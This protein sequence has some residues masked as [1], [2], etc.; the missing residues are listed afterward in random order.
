MRL[1]LMAAI[2]I[3]L[4]NILLQGC[5]WVD[6]TGRQDNLNPILSLKDGDILYQQEEGSFQIDASDGASDP[7]G[8]TLTYRWSELQ[9]QG[10]LQ[11][12]EGTIDLTLAADKLE[13]ICEDKDNCELLFLQ[14]EEHPG[15]YQVMVPKVTAPIGLTHNLHVTDSDGGETVLSTHFCIDSNN[16]AP[17]AIDDN[18]AATEG[19][20]LEVAAP[21]IRDNDTDD[22][23]IRNQELTILGLA[24]GKGPKYAQ[25]GSFVLNSDGSF[26]YG[27]SIFTPLT[28]TQDSFVYEISDGD[29]ISQATVVI[30]LSTQNDPPEVTPISAKIAYIGKLFGPLNVGAHFIDPEGAPM[31]FSISQL[32]TGLRM[33][34]KGIISGSPLIGNQL[35]LH[36]IVISAFDGLHAKSLTLSLTL[37]NNLNKP[38]QLISVIPAINV[39]V[40][41]ALGYNLGQHFKDPENKP[42]KYSAP[43]GLP[44]SFIIQPNGI[45]NGQAVLADIGSH[46]VTLVVSDGELSINKTFILTI[47]SNK[48]PLQK[49]P[50][51]NVLLHVGDSVNQNIASYFADPEG[52]TMTYTATGLPLSKNITLSSVGLLS[53]TA[54][55]VDVT[56]PIAKV[57]TITVTDASGMTKQATMRLKILSP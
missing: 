48:P 12:C 39:G 34:K 11:V 42:L 15:L 29:K 33:S 8:D 46:T 50:I 3:L 14:N 38:P 55:A 23:D 25:T 57:I 49:K 40:G 56:G 47:K 36:Q 9:D 19:V 31:T 2:V 52:E 28:Q 37:K 1:S 45:L 16:E 13:D 10:V 4:T 27:V 26:S 7:D 30:N 17:N 32:P 41:V 21:G 54:Q 22:N 43:S 35:G 5:N 18:Y 24:E 51:S 6:S 20:L 53:G 44:V